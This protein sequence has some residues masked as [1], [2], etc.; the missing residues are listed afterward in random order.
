MC[1]RVCPQRL[2]R[3]RQDIESWLDYGAFCLLTEDTLKAQE[4]F[5][6]AL[7][8]NAQH[9]RRYVFASVCVAPFR[10]LPSARGAWSCESNM[11]DLI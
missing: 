9:L 5:R 3:D 2:T 11:P 8:L 7:A 4:C 1:W 10:D 6:E